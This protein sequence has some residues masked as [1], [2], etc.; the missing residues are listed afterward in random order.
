MNLRPAFATAAV[1]VLAACQTADVAT[2]G[3]PSPLTCNRVLMY[4]NAA[5]S[6][7][8]RS[9]SPA[10]QNLWV[11]ELASGPDIHTTFNNSTAL[12]VTVRGSGCEG[13]SYLAGNWNNLARQQGQPQTVCGVNIDNYVNRLN[14]VPLA[15]NTVTSAFTAA[16]AAGRI[17]PAVATSYINL[18]C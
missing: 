16:Q 3:V 5:T 9:L 8:C 17:T 7:L 18:G 14:A 13:N 15:H 11:C 2:V 10:T 1:L 12:H 4:G 6:G